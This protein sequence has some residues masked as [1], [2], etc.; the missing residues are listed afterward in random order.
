LIREGRGCRDKGEAAM[1]NSAAV[2][3]GPGST[4]RDTRNNIFELFC[5]T[6]TPNERKM[7]AVSSF[8]MKENREAH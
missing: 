8:Q 5:R 1:N 6:E 3:Q 7:L 4:S 2:E